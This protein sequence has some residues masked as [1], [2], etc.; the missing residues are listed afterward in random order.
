MNSA[1]REI[2]GLQ[3]V[4]PVAGE[5]QGIRKQ[6]YQQLG[7]AEDIQ[8]EGLDAG[9]MYAQLPMDA[10]ALDARQDAQVGGKPGGIYTRGRAQHLLHPHRMLQPP[11]GRG[12]TPGLT[13]P[14]PRSHNTACF[15]AC[16]SPRR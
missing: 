4:I 6:L 13:Y 14:G 9:I 8:G 7:G 2:R 3:R 11:P 1:S 15:P 16:S 12:N 10:G 5:H